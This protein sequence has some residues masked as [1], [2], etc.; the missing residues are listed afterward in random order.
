MTRYVATVLLSVLPALPASGA[1]PLPDA[2]LHGTVH[3]NGEQIIATDPPTIRSRKS[4]P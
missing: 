4:R 3:I 1:I 2:L